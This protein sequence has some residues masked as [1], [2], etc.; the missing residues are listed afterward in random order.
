MDLVEA[1][2]KHGKTEEDVAT[3]AGVG[4]PMVKAVIAGKR[5]FYPSRV[6]SVL[7]LFK[8]DL[9]SDDLYRQKPPPQSKRKTA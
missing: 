2:K 3:A 1:M 4:V 6:P 5:W 9:K 7:K 8:G